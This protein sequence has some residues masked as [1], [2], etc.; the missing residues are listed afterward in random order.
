[1]TVRRPMP[2]QDRSRC[3]ARWRSRAAIIR[4]TLDEGDM[5]RTTRLFATLCAAGLTAACGQRGDV[6]AGSTAAPQPSVA[7]PAPPPAPPPLLAAHVELLPARPT[8]AV[9]TTAS[10]EPVLIRPESMTEAPQAG[11]TI[12]SAPATLALPQH[13]SSNEA[14]AIMLAWQRYCARSPGLSADDIAT[15]YEYHLE[16]LRTPAN[17]GDP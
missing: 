9:L 4:S 8:G 15:V 6:V 17:C 3:A 16:D 11:T 10:I 5:V 7:A 2:S 13:I 14:A 12:S 1:M